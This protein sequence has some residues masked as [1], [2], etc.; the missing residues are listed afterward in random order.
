MFFKC[1]NC[2]RAQSLRVCTKFFHFSS[3]AGSLTAEDRWAKCWLLCQVDCWLHSERRCA[4]HCVSM[5]RNLRLGLLLRLIRRCG[6]VNLP[7]D[8]TILLPLQSV[9]IQP[10]MSVGKTQPI[11][12]HPRN[13]YDGCHLNTKM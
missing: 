12:M 8:S 7:T 2:F 4:K 11:V 10:S 6:N 13:T 3:M 1:H 5:L 9:D